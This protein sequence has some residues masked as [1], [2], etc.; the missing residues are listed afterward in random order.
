MR[1]KKKIIYTSFKEWFEDAIQARKMICWASYLCVNAILSAVVSSIYY[2]WRA[3]RDF[4]KREP[5]AFFI[6]FAVVVILSYGWLITYV[7]MRG[8]VVRA[9]DMLDSISYKTSIRMAR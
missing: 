3:I 7:Q 6:V 1:A 5:I 4:Y 9:Q 2:I 8:K